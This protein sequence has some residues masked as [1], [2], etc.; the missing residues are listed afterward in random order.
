LC[1][2]APPASAHCGGI[3][4][5]NLYNY[6]VQLHP[7]KSVYRVGQTAK[8]HMIVTRPGPQDPLGLGVS[9]D[10]PYKEP[11]ADVNVGIGLRV[12]DVFLFGI[13]VTNEKGEAIVPIKLLPYTPTG[14]AAA[15]AVGWQIVHQNTCLTVQEIG[16][17]SDPRAF[18][19]TR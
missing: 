1:A 10:P 17:A 19:V 13:A 9:W 11:A 8:F 15:D 6:T 2:F 5:V 4:T 12:G 7:K 18:K 14:T 16:Y 3:E